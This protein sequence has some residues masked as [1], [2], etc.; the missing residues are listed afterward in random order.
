V[1]S[2][3]KKYTAPKTPRR[4]CQQGKLVRGMIDID[5]PSLN[6]TFV[7]PRSLAFPTL[8][9]FARVIE[10]RMTSETSK[11]LQAAVKPARAYTLFAVK[12]SKSQVQ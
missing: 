2:T 7:S 3:Y 1:D 10:N 6:K 11:A 9:A 8:N 5:T 12:L 4:E